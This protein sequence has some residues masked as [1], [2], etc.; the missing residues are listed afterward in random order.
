MFQQSVGFRLKAIRCY[1]QEDQSGMGDIVGVTQHAWHY[2]E[3]GRTLIPA[4]R[5][6]SIIARARVNWDYI[7]EGDKERLPRYLAD[8]LDVAEEEVRAGRFN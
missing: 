1:L 7:Y 6:R 4:E 5:A 8:K 3:I 2:Y